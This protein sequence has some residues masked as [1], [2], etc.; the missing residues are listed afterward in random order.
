MSD[1]AAA[2]DAARLTAFARAFKAAARSVVLYPESHPAIAATLGRLTQLTSPPQLTA[3]FRISVTADALLLGGAAVARPDAALGELA[4]LLHA[5]LVGEL[6]VLPGGDQSAWR[7]FLLLLGRAP[8]AVREEGGVA[9]LW[10][11]MAGRHVEVREIDYA[12]V[13]RERTPGAAVTWKDVVASCLAGNNID[14]PE[15]L[16][17]ALLDGST[18]SDALADV[19][20]AFDHDS[21]DGPGLQARAAAL[22]RL[23]GGLV[24][25]V[26]ARAPERT[27]AVMRELADAMARLTPEML[28]TLTR[29]PAGQPGAEG[30][31][32]ALHAVLGH[33]SDAAIAHFVAAR[34]PAPGASLE[35]VVEA[36][37]SLVVDGDRRERLVAMARE[38]AAQEAAGDAGFEQ[39]WQGVAQKLLTQYSDESYVSDAYARELGMARTQA[40]QIEQLHEDPP[41]RIAAWLGS[42]STT[43]LRRLDL[44][45]MLDLLR[46]EQNPAR[47][48][49]LATPLLMLLEDLFLVGDFEAAQSL[50]AALHDEAAATPGGGSP[51]LGPAVTTRLLTP[52]TMRHL[53]GH[54]GTIE[55]PQFERVRQICLLLGEQLVTPLAEALA[56]EERTR[57]RE[58]LTELLIGFGRIG[59]QHVEQL[60]SS[61]NPAVRRT[62]I[63]LLREFGGSEAL[64]ELA[65]LLDDAEPGVQ[66]DAVRAILN[67]G[68]DHG[69][70]VLEQAL[71]GGTPRSRDAIM[72]ALGSRDER[73]TPLLVYIVEHVD[74]RGALQWVYIRALELLG[75]ARDPESVPA[76]TAALHRGEWW[77]PRRTKALRSVAAAALARVGTAA[78]IEALGQ[79]AANGSRGVRRVAAPHLDTARHRTRGGQR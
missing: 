54:L 37:Q 76:L 52:P 59:R 14:I 29:Q 72:H 60:K 4:E 44:T 30:D 19:L 70:R 65:E 73:A 51:A 17:L 3:P 18:T 64:P 53:V 20:A 58:R 46:L 55:P 40:I 50:L 28:A 11:T 36:F 13:L 42:V 24:R 49:G 34:A 45:L 25:A 47:R 8:E 78:A 71:E 48:A 23:L 5:H 75:Q 33:M 77:A 62:A 7:Q 39:R 63:Y 12:E 79:A 35:R 22:V 27:D 66:R 16:L 6:T 2:R 9:R 68:T 43:E 69:Y 26:T 56:A 15:E 61:A 74:H 1:V 57:T 21:A 38:S 67:I 41:E 32:P 31:E 10:A